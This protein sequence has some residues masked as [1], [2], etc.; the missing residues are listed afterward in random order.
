MTLALNP[1]LSQ[2]SRSVARAVGYTPNTTAIDTT[3]K[4]QSGTYV[5]EWEGE[6]F[7]E[8]AKSTGIPSTI[9]NPAVDIVSYEVCFLKPIDSQVSSPTYA[10]GKVAASA[11]HVVMPMGPHVPVILEML[12]KGK[13]IKA[14]NVHK[15]IVVGN[16]EL[17]ISETLMFSE[18]KVAEVRISAEYGVQLIIQYDK[19][20]FTVIPINKV[21]GSAKGIVAFGWDYATNAIAVT[22]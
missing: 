1:G 6:S 3:Q 13:Y 8:N 18:A 16:T 4:S 22:K 19:F 2:G 17:R 14:V 5:L 7:D 9:T 20:D 12:H 21:D 15:V 10:T 11:L